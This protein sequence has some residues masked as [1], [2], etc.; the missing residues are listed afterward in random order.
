MDK[1]ETKLQQ[2]F[3][4]HYLEKSKE[5]SDRNGR[6]VQ[7]TS[8]EAAVKIIKNNEIWLRNTQCMNDYQEV[9]YGLDCLVKAY[10]SKSGI[11]LRSF[12]NTMFPESTIEFE[13]IFN[14]MIPDIKLHS[15]IA[16]F[17]EHQDHED[18]TGRL[19]MWRAYGNDCPVA[20]VF[21]N[22]PFFNET[23]VL[24]AYS[25]AVYYWG[26]KR[27]QSEFD[28]IVD[29]VCSEVDFIRDAGKDKFFT[30]FLGFCITSLLCVKHPG[31]LEEKEWRVV[32]TPK[33]AH[34]EHVDRSVE[35]IDSVPQHIF[36]IPLRNIPEKKLLGFSIP[37]IIDRVIIGPTN[38]QGVLYQAFV[39]LLKQAG[40]GDDIASKVVASG[41]PLR[42]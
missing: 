3:N 33:L 12:L 17:S 38:N 28:I 25:S 34:S 4:S 15:Y 1:I 14:S 22:S 32:Y 6:F 20:L 40:C 5:V 16:C 30:Y 13:K 9:S 24:K 42:T 27:Y 23:D 8:A 39:D 2:I 18:D 31:F 7:Y 19:S 11:R 29:R 26:H 36:K 37:E 21:K 10:D 41:I 35:L